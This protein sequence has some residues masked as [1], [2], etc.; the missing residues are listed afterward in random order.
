MEDKNVFNCGAL[1]SKVDLRD[2]KVQAVATDIVEFKLDNLPTIKNQYSVCSCV[3][4]A[5]SYILEWFNQIETNEYRELSVG[6]IYGMQGVEFNR[7]GEGMYLR[8]ACKII[9]KYG[10]CLNDTVPFNVEMPECYNYLKNRLNDEVYN[11][12]LICKVDS[13]AKCETDEAVKYALIKYSPVAMSVKW[14]VDC[15]L[16]DDGVISFDTTSKSGYHAVMV[17][18]FNERGWL[19]QNSYGKGWGNDGRFVLP[20]EHGYKE[21]WSFVDAENCN[22]H[23]PKQSKVLDVIYKILNFV[24]NLFNF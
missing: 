16:D 15:K 1:L 9:Q 22:V 3:A 14:Y 2:Y 13:Y 23:K 11:E 24:I 19:C 8:D 7:V 18:G 21:A 17:Y 10:D 4:H 12:A 20:Y 6:F 5:L